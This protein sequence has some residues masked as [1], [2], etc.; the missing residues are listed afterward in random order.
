LNHIP[1]PISYRLE[2]SSLRRN[3]SAANLAILR[4][5]QGMARK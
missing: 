3:A 5:S 2:Q 4:K 1:F